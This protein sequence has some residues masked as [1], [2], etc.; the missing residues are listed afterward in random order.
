MILKYWP[1]RDESMEF[2]IDSLKFFNG[3]QD[4][5]DENQQNGK[6]HVI[7]SESEDVKDIA[8]RIIIALRKN[9]TTTE[10][11]AFIVLADKHLHYKFV[12]GEIVNRELILQIPVGQRGWKSGGFFEIL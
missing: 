11:D 1:T 12:D 6:L 4:H 3:V 8:V 5:E 2:S 7:V 10:E 9:Y